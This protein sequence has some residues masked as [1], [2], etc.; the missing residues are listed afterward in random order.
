MR[1]FIGVPLWVWGCAC[2][3][4]SIVWIFL[5]PQNAVSASS[6]VRF[7]I[8]R[9]FHALVW[10]VLAVA[11]F[12]AGFDILGGDGLPGLLPYSRWRST[13]YLWQPF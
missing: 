13:S 6:G 1:P 4:L 9:W 2:L 8:I 7:F 12:I 5:W 11:A 3:L 10:L